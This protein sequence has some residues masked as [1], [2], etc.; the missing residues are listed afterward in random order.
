MIVVDASAL[1][2]LLLGGPRA[3]E[4]GGLLLAQG[5]PLAAP[6]LIELEVA[7][8]MRRLAS[9][10]RLDPERAE[11]AFDDL[12]AMPL[13]RYDHAPLL[14]RIWALREN[15]TAYDAAYLALAEALD[16]PLVT[17]D[18]AL[19]AAPGRMAEVIVVG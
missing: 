11:R 1:L 2:E 15:L 5:T 13:A 19:R 6:Q 14:P 3:R 8:V 16:A 9:R 10:G 7:Q 18:A 4:L 12:A 17:C